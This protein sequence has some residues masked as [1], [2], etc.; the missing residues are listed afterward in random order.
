[1]S[2]PLRHVTW[3][4]DIARPLELKEIEEVF[5]RFGHILHLHVGDQAPAQALA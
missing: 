1:M 2:A 5:V 4:V 3:N